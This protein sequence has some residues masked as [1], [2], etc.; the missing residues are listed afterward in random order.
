MNVDKIFALFDYKNENKPLS[1]NDNAVVELYETPLFWVSMFEKLIQNNNIFKQQL[2]VM[3]KHDEYYDPEMLMEAGDAVVYNR[4]YSFI[5]ALDM[6]NDDHKNALRIRTKQGYL[7]NNLTSAMDHFIK[8]EEYEKCTVIKVIL[9]FL[10][11]SLE[12]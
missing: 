12:V 11:E 7:I 4:A 9:K 5:K 6:D 1:E 3:F 8:H 2:K 10:Q